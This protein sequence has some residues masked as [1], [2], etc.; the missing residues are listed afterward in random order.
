MTL[1]PF[2]GAGGFKRSGCMS[3][4]VIMEWT[5]GPG[6]WLRSGSDSRLR[7][8]LVRLGS[9]DSTECWTKWEILECGASDLRFQEAVHVLMAMPWGVGIRVAAHGWGALGVDGFLAPG[10]DARGTLF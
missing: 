9:T 2:S 5:G 10:R 8:G 7:S 6:G 1:D 4:S 3:R